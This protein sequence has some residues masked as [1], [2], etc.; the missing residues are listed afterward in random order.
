MKKVEKPAW[1]LNYKGED[2]ALAKWNNRMDYTNK[3]MGFFDYYLKGAPQP[4]WMRTR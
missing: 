3:V 1:L 2:H 4:D